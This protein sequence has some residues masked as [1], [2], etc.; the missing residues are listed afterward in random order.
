M[1]ET[2]AQRTP[3]ERLALIAK[4]S[5]ELEEEA[6]IGPIERRRVWLTTGV[7]KLVA[8]MPAEFLELN[9]AQLLETQK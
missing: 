8:A 1:P 6:R 3:Q 9:R 5:G 2:S 7:I 4:L